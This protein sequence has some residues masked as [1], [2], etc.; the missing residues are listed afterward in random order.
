MFI[1]PSVIFIGLGAL[2]L[3]VAAKPTRSSKKEVIVIDPKDDGPLPD[4][5]DEE[6]KL[7]PFSGQCF[8]FIAAEDGGP[9]AGEFFYEPIARAIATGRGEIILITCDEDPRLE[10]AFNAACHQWGDAY[11][12]SVFSPASLDGVPEGTA[13]TELI[14]LFEDDICT[15]SQGGG[16]VL[17][18]RPVTGG[19]VLFEG[20]NT[21]SLFYVL[22]QEADPAAFIEH[23]V[24]I[25][26]GIV[27]PGT[28]EHVAAP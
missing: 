23:A 7:P 6:G 22:D 12:F 14:D 20:E 26:A 5:E 18:V 24:A 9:A 19:A 28:G 11:Q 21:R 4:D 2:A 3:G 13:K 25:L 27:D 16:T 15:P 17:I 10:D 1:P 8:T